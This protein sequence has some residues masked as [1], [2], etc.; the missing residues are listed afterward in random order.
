MAEN[1]ENLVVGL[2]PARGGSKGIPRK[3]ILPLVGKPLIAWTIDAAREAGILDRIIV[4]T[5]DREIAE[6]ARASGAEVPFLRPAELARDDTPGIAPVL[7]AIDALEKEGYRPGWVMMLQPTS[8]LRT[9]EDI[10]DA[11]AMARRTG[12][13]VV[14]SVCEAAPPPAWMKRI[15][16]DGTLEDYFPQ[17]LPSVRQKL[18]P[19]YS[20]NGAF[21]LARVSALRARNS[22]YG[23]RVHAFVMP[24]ERSID[25]DTPWDFELAG[26]ILSRRR[27]P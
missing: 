18:A 15:T 13:E 27:G 25:I 2:I 10:R 1:G 21:Y 7:H 19:A 9:S 14:V 12:A 6:T 4:S 20:L 26:T 16:D 3:N 8:P 17:E 11:W 22:F 24:R 5:D 23:G